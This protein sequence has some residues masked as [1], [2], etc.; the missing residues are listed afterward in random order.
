[1]AALPGVA[2]IHRST[3]FFFTGEAQILMLIGWGPFRSAR[4]T[5][6]AVIDGGGAPQASRARLRA[7]REDERTADDESARP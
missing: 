6:A 5:L 2:I 3:I 7:G 4:R 1:M